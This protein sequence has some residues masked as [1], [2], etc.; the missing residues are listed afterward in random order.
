M[1]KINLLVSISDHWENFLHIHVHSCTHRE[2]NH[3]D[4]KLELNF[5]D[6]INKF[7]L[8]VFFL[9]RMCVCVCVCT[10]LRGFSCVWLFA[11]LW[12]V[13]LKLVCPW[14]SPGKNKGVSCHFL[15]QGFFWPKNRTHVSCISCNGRQILYQW[16]HLGSPTL[17]IRDA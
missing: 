13:A 5:I 10:C 11:I 9:I 15:L 2:L 7:C 16:C 17:N 14:D 6:K 12:T 8:K 4:L 1:V 3:K